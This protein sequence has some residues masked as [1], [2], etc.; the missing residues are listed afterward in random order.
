ML[1][2]GVRTRPRDAVQ[3]CNRGEIDDRA[4]TLAQHLLN[5]RLHAVVQP[6]HVGLDHAPERRAVGLSECLVLVGDAGVVDRH[7]QA[8][9]LGHDGLDHL[10]H[11]SFVGDVV[12]DEERS[13]A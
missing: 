10:A 5:L 11:G 4:A 2:G 6:E 3:P 13:L 12:A 1:G 9:V 8:A 7:V